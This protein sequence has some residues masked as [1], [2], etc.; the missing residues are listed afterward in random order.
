MNAVAG[1]VVRRMLLTLLTCVALSTSAAALSTSAVLSTPRSARVHMC[2]SPLAV[3]HHPN[4][5]VP[6]EVQDEPPTERHAES[7]AT[8]PGLSESAFASMLDRAALSADDLSSTPSRGIFCTRSLDMS[9]IKCIGYDMDY[10]LVP[11]KV[12]VWEG[13]AYHYCKEHLRSKGFPVSGLE[14]TPE[15]V[16]RGIIIDKEKGNLV[17]ADRF[18]YVRRAMHG[19]RRLDADEIL[20]EYRG[21]TIDLRSERWTFTNTL[22]SVSECCLYAQLVERLDSG[23]LLDK[24]RPPFDARRCSTYAQLFDAVSHALFKAHVTSTLKEEVMSE[25]ERFI[26]PDPVNAAVLLE[27]RGAGKKLALITNSDWTYTQTLMR[28]CYDPFLPD[29][30]S[31]TDVFDLVVVSAC[32]PEFFATERR[33]V[34][35][36]ATDEGLFREHFRFEQ[37]RR[38]AGGNA[39]MLEK[40][41]KLEGE[42]ILY[43]GDHL[44]SDVNVAKRG[45][46]WRTALIMQELESEIDGLAKGKRATLELDS[47]LASHEKHTSLLSRLQ[48]EFTLRAAGGHRSSDGPATRDSVALLA[49]IGALEDAVAALDRTIA[50]LVAADGDHVNRHWGYM[51]R[52]G[53]LDKSHLMRQ[54]EKYADIYTSRVSNFLPVRRSLSPPPKRGTPHIPPHQTATHRCHQPCIHLTAC[55]RAQYT[56]YSRFQAARALLAHDRSVVSRRGLDAAASDAESGSDHQL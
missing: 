48:S 14:F 42:D 33:P 21:L 38:F 35:E 9:T 18:G 52:A 29:G 19:T 43:I 10:T 28:T 54:V 15:L 44:F 23:E 37:G 46:S 13:R 56:P 55:A 24:S 16:C 22:F 30:M 39:A 45:L 8:W 20:R 5:S 49:D 40:A 17:K 25:P 12:E 26:S 11:Y 53:H 36:I 1:R 32:K 50:P 31:W 41:F 7:F 2:E 51:S 34:Y 27:Q 3:S 6:A 47:L 4:P